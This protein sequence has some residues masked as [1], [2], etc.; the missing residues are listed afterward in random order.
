M[1]VGVPDRAGRRDILR[2]ILESMGQLQREAGAVGAQEPGSLDAATIDQV[3]GALPQS[4]LTR[5]RAGRD[6]GARLRGRGPVL[7]VPTGE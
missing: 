3:R 5:V 1:E 2:V 4:A 7:H 6:L